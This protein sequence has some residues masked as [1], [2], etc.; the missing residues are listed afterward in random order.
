[1]TQPSP[2]VVQ[3]ALIT[4]GSRGLGRSMALHLAERGVDS[5][6][7]YQSRAE[8]ARAVV[9]E[10]ERHGRRAIALPLDVSQS[11]S[12][13]QFTDTLKAELAR[14]WNRDTF[15]AL[16]NNAGV[17]SNSPFTETSEEQFDTMLKV[18]L[19][20]PYFL[21]QKLLPLLA[22]G[23]RIVNVSSGLARFSFPGYSAYAIMKGAVD[24]L[25]RYLAL[26]LGP[27]GI[28]VNSLAPGAIETDFGGGTLR[29]NPQMKAAIAAHTALGRVGH[30]DD[31][32]GL[33]ALLLSPE[34]R[35]INGQRIEAS[36]G[37]SL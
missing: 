37:I 16:V 4:G 29:N 8:D 19:K 25:T 30:P 23:G 12:F 1:M 32:G 28:S 31:I 34:S 35:W 20:G 24:V 13:P 18:H 11:S 21:T 26:E 6:I 27:R 15:D 7:T 14:G 3:L 10:I 5:I 2:R 22:S 17:G 9:A 36:G 33:L